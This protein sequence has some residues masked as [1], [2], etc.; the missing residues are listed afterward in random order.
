ML[1]YYAWDDEPRNCCPRKMR[2]ATVEKLPGQ[3]LQHA[4]VR[5]G[6]GVRAVV[7]SGPNPAS[8]WVTSPRRRR[9]C[10]VFWPMRHH[11]RQCRST[12]ELR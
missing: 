3:P 4:A 5:A 6:L 7:P 9:R 1:A 12:D 2:V 10:V 8:P 11:P